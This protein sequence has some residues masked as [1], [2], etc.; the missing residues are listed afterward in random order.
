MTVTVGGA[1][2]GQVRREGERR[3]RSEKEGKEVERDRKGMRGE[4][5]GR[6]EAETERRE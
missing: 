4:E 5:T 1:T 6:K 3:P 2:E